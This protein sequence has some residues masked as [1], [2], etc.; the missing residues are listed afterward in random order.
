MSFSNIINS[1][2]SIRNYKHDPIPEEMLSKIL[3][4]GRLAPSACNLQ[5][6]IFV[7]LK[8]KEQVSRLASAYDREWLLDAPA[9]I[10]VCIDR[11]TSWKRSDGR[12]YGDVDAA[13]AMDYMILQAAELGL[14]TCWIANFKKE[15]LIKAVDIPE[16]FEPVVLTPVGFPAKMPDV[17]P[18]KSIEEIVR[19]V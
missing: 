18:R 8:G 7:V 9:V 17:R 6:W 11:K 5:P 13:I 10:I 1:R 3:E 12:D 14:G 4:A 2:R 19:Y 16:G 15:S